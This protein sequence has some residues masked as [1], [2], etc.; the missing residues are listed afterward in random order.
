MPLYEFECKSCKKNL[1]KALALLEKKYDKKT[2]LSLIKKFKNL[3]SNLYIL[4]WDSIKT[5]LPVL[6][7]QIFF[8]RQA[9]YR[10]QGGEAP[11]PIQNDL[12]LV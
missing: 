11:Q 10:L 12:F 9:K 5:F 2:L 6:N 3:N 1:M 8:L 7:K 4:I